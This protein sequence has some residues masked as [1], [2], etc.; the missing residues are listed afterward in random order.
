MFVDDDFHPH[1]PNIRNEDGSISVYP[2]DQNQI[3]RKWRNA[4]SI[5]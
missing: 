1:S 5:C 2:I 3:E 4:T